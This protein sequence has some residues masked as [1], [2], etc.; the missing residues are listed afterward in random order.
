M[1]LL[2]DVEAIIVV[3]AVQHMSCL[4][5]TL[6]LTKI[7]KR[8]SRGQRVSSP[9]ARSRVGDVTWIL[10]KDSPRD[11]VIMK[12]MIPRTGWRSRVPRSS[13]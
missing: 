13:A 8:I 10:R 3:Q 4:D 12:W 6:V 5:L 1:G 11:L 9:A 7:T 2:R